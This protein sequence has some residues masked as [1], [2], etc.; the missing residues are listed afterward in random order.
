[1]LVFAGP[2][3]RKQISILISSLPSENNC[4]DKSRLFQLTQLGDT[5]EEVLAGALCIM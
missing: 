4:L 5:S 3:W 2:V 1:M